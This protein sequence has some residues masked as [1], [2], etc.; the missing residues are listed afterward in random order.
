MKDL[1]KPEAKKQINNLTARIKS[2]YPHLYESAGGKYIRK[3]LRG[4]LEVYD[5]TAQ[6]YNYYSKEGNNPTQV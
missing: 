6:D 2:R 4:M 5:S 3:I 1:A